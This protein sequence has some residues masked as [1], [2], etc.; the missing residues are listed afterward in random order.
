MKKLFSIL[1]AI[2]SLLLIVPGCSGGAVS[3]HPVKGEFIEG[4]LG[5]TAQ[6]LNWI[7]AT[8]AGASRRYAGFMVDPLGVYDN[9]FKVQLRCLAKEIEV[10]ADGLTYTAVIRN[11]LKWTDGTKVTAE[12]YVFTLKNLMF[13]DWLE[14]ENLA[15]WQETVDGKTALVVPQVVGE[16]TFKI[17]RKTVDPDF[18]Y[19]LYDLMPYP[20]TIGI[21]Y[22]NK[23]EAFTQAPEFANLTYSG[24][25]GPYKPVAWSATEGFVVRRNPDYYLGK[26]TGAPYFEK[27]TIKQFG[28]QAMLTEALS[29]GKVSY[30]YIE[31][32]EANTLRGQGNTNVYA[33]P[34]GYYVYMAYNQRDN[35]WEGLKDPR[36]RQAISMMINK[37]AIVQTMYLGYADP[38]ATFIPPYSPWYNSSVVKDYGMDPGRDQKTAI[39]LIKSA[40]YTQKE[41]DGQMKFVD[42]DG[43]PIKLTFLI[44]MGSEFE[45]NLAIIIRQ[46]LL[47]IGL[48]INPRFS[49]REVVFMNGLMNKVPESDQT[50]TFNNGP[51]AVSKQSWDLVILSSHA[52]PLALEG[53]QEFFTT[54]GKFNL[55][56]YFNPKVDELYKRGKSI[57][58][59]SQEN[60][61]KIYS[62]LAQTISEAQP[63]DFLV[64]YKDNY[65]F[66]KGVKGVEPGINVLYNYQFWYLE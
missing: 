3:L 41:I 32:V 61:K 16:T 25:L 39:E 66:G 24:N 44:D 65:V 11:D 9:A 14:Y 4:Q 31:P 12:D 28:L 50:P 54:T 6:T 29:Q 5:D 2:V 47:N 10:S 48:D 62:E 21:H 1:L 19:T 26:E 38:A 8:D 18:L 35:G 37:P 36:V 63:V 40:G 56:G 15:K 55:F 53:S 43:N 49:T 23:S 57:E 22:E 27:Y 34:T 51:K 45:Q 52:N 64:F 46:C 42:K 59:I 33:V 30:G 13:A 58:G 7:V 20:K 17:L 60:R